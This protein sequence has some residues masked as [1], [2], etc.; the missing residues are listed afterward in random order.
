M[1]SMALKPLG[2]EMEGCTSVRTIDGQH[3]RFVTSRYGAGLWS[4]ALWKAAA[5]RR[6]Y[7]TFAKKISQKLWIFRAGTPGRPK[8]TLSKMVPPKFQAPN[9][10]VEART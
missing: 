5:V 3:C 9:F 6:R 7:E 10:A 2:I 1:E 4:F 8:R